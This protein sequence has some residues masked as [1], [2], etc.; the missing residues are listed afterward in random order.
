VSW[1]YDEAGGEVTTTFDFSLSQKAESSASG[2]L[3]G[4]LPHQHKY[5]S[6]SFTGY[7]YTS[8]RG[9]IKTISGVG[10]FTTSY[11][12]PGVL[13]F[14]PDEG[15]YDDTELASYVDE[16]EA[17]STL[18][19]T[20]PD[21]PGDGTYWTGKNYGR[22]SEADPH[23]RAGQR[24]HHRRLLHQRR[25]RHEGDERR[26]GDLARRQRI[27]WHQVRGRL[28]LRRQLGHA[29]RLQRLLRLR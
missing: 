18:I 4:L 8:A 6:E 12:F 22:L 24:H 26:S 5:T 13:P 20:G 11:S 25:Q 17:N 29:D 15:T 21:R 16:E 2:T 23:R 10:S 14:M 27:W 9:S 1:T 19:E 28:L 3:T 7:T